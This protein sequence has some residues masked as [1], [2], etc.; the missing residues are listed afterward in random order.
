MDEKKQNKG[1]KLSGKSHQ[2]NEEL[3]RAPKTGL[4]RGFDALVC[5]LTMHSYIEWDPCQY[6]IAACVYC[7]PI[8]WY[9]FL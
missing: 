8:L 6:H 9:F 5:S 3:K 4:F 2:T 1:K 7:N